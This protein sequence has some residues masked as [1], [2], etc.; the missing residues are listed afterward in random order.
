VRKATRILHFLVA[1]L[2]WMNFVPTFEDEVALGRS[3]CMACR[4]KVLVIPPLRPG[5]TGIRYAFHRDANLRICKLSGLP[6]RRKQ[7]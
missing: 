4:Q 7:L 1:L 6:M 5:E 2:K 3:T